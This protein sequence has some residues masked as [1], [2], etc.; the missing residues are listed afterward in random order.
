[1]KQF[2]EVA[3]V[4]IG[5]NEGER[6][7]Q[8]LQSLLNSVSTIVYVD[9]GSTDNS[10]EVAKSLGVTTVLLDLSVP[11]TAAR[12]RNEGA[13]HLLKSNPDILYIQFIDGDCEIRPDWIEKA[14]LFLNENTKYAVACGRRR[15]RMPKASIYNQLCDIEWNTAI[16]NALACGGDALVRVTAFQ[17]VTGYNGKLIAAEEPEM[18][19][20]LRE[21]GW[22]IRRIDAEMTLH[23]AAITQFSQWW[24]RSVRTGYAFVL[25]CSMHGHSPERYLVRESRR[26][27]FWGLFL[28]G[29]FV[30]SWFINPLFSLIIIF[31]YGIQII[32]VGWNKIVEGNRPFLWAAGVVLGKIPEAIGLIR[33]WYDKIGNKTSRIIEYKK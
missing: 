32:R 31:V 14:K 29:L 11:F 22:K 5:R 15:E 19:F 6:L 10:L 27:Y 23:D 2:I 3:A 20:R 17:Q 24:K 33:F 1:L 13:A 12:A 25:G 28:P 4:V 7:V 16:G 18:C 9:S 30:F 8:C 26:I 21:Q